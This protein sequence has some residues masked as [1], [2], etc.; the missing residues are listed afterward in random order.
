VFE[1]ANAKSSPHL[2]ARRT[3][4][5]HYIPCTALCKQPIADYIQFITTLIKNIRRIQS[6]VASQTRSRNC[7]T[8]QECHQLITKTTFLSYFLT[9][10]KML[11]TRWFSTAGKYFV[12]RSIKIIVNLLS[13]V[14]SWVGKGWGERVELLLILKW[15]LGREIV[16]IIDKI[17]GHGIFGR[18][19]QCLPPTPPKPT[20]F[21]MAPQACWYFQNLLVWYFS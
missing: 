15:L 3:H 2:P 4:N 1:R 11:K 9:A 18:T 10:F 13:S 5:Y 7:Y 8:A 6:D 19:H 12:N 20:A 21:W 17:T 14:F 16:I